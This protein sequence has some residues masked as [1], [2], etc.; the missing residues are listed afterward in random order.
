[1]PT[2]RERNGRWQAQVRLKKN[3]VIIHQESASFD[4]KRQA[5]LWGNSLEAKLLKEGVESYHLKRQTLTDLMLAYSA[6]RESIRPLGR[7]TQHSIKALCLAP[8]SN[9]PLQAI[10]AQDL[11][12][13][14]KTLSETLAPATV[15]HH[16][17][18]MRS[19]YQYAPSL[20]GA[21]PDLEP[22]AAAMQTLQRG[23]VLAKSQS[24]DRRVSD[25]ELN[26]IV[27]HLMGKFLMVPTHTFVRLAV[28]LPRRREELLTMRW[29]DYTGTTIKLRDTKNPTRPRDEVIPIPPAAK[30]IIDALPRFEGES[31]ILPYK[32]ESVSAAFQRAVREIGLSD[33]RLHDL[34]HEGISRLFEAGL[35][36][37]EVALI[38]GHTSWAALRRYTHIK[39][40]DVVEKLNARQQKT[41]KAP[42]QSER[43][44]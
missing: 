40:L 39:P 10:T 35:Q 2:I 30:K 32:P 4:T 7:G 44:Q 17:M 12:V 23:K 28:A 25:D 22:V 1:M 42:A 34:R 38:S 3:G 14:G 18:I 24:R 27:Q 6:Y 11:T 13:W 16:F 31:R 9:K 19:A 29:D 36:I 5:Q 41:Q 15:L 8:F 26:Q 21:T 37:Q 33:I 43:A 20:V